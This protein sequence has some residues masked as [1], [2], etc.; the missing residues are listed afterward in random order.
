MTN[1]LDIIHRLFLIKTHVSETEVCLRVICDWF[2]SSYLPRVYVV[3][4]FFILYDLTTSAV[5]L[6]R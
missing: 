3:L 6:V 5:H 4:L 2:S 1:L